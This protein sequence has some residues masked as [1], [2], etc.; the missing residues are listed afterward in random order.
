MMQLNKVIKLTRGQ[1][2]MGGQKILI[3]E[4]QNCS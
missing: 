3:S 2:Q 4:H 1:R